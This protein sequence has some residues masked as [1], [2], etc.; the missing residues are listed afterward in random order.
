MAAQ[1]IA[2]FY[3]VYV[4]GERSPVFQHNSHEAAQTEAKRLCDLTKKEA[5]VLCPTVSFKPHGNYIITEF[6]T[7]DLPF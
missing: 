2:P 5:F 1:K 4:Q 3:M 7:D 6:S